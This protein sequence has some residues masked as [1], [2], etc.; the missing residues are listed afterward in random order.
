MASTRTHLE[1]LSAL[2]PGV[3]QGGS[4]VSPLTTAFPS[5]P[6]TA[7]VVPFCWIY[8]LSLAWGACLASELCGLAIVTPEPRPFSGP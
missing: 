3:P 8:T 6:G 1:V 4:E 7:T 2:A 5:L